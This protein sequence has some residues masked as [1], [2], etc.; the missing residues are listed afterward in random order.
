MMSGARQS[1]HKAQHSTRRGV[2]T[3]DAGV[4]APIGGE[5]KPRRAGRRRESG[6]RGVHARVGQK[7]GSRP[8]ISFPFT[9]FFLSPVF[10]SLYL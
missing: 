6:P 3:W 1:A 9:F 4:W 5:S 8:T 10:F 2:T 7:R